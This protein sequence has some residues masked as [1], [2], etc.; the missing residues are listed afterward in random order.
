MFG[1]PKLQVK[2]RE[3]PYARSCEAR[4]MITGRVLRMFMFCAGCRVRLLRA[5]RMFNRHIRR[6]LSVFNFSRF[7]LLVNK[8]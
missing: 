3:L 8:L 2:H 7:L 4:R 6:A 5:Q 1:E